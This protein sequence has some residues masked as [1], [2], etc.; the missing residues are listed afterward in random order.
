MG[1]NLFQY[2][3]IKPILLLLTV[4]TFIQGICIILQ[5]KWLAEVISS[6]FSGQ[7][8][9]SQL[10]KTIFFLIAFSLRHFIG[11]LQQK[12]AFQFAEKT[13][14]DLRQQFVTKLFE[15]GPRFTKHHGTGNLVT[16][17][18]EGIN[19]FRTY[20]E[21]ILPRMISMGVVPA[22]VLVYIFWKDFISG[23]ILTVT[24]PIL[25]AFLILVGLT[26]KKQMDQQ[27]ASY[28]VLSNHF[29]DSLRG[30]ETLKFLGKSKAHSSSIERVSHKYRKAT[31]GTLKVA[32]L[33]S[34]SLDFFSMLSIASVAVGLGMR[35]IDGDLML[36]TALSVLIL[37][38]EYF[39]PVR[40]VGAD[41]HATL[42]GKEA[43]EAIQ[44]ILKEPS[45]E[46]M[47]DLKDLSEELQSPTKQNALTLSSISVFQEE[48]S[49]PTLDDISFSLNGR[50]KVGI[51]GES[52]AGKS[53]LIDVLS[54]FLSPS[55]GEIRLN[56]QIIPL[57]SQAWRN[58][59]T[60]I[61]QK[62]Y[63]FSASVTDNIR[64]YTPEATEEEINQAIKAAGLS[65]MVQSLP[66][67][68]NEQIGGGGRSLSGGQEQR[69]ALA[70]AF[71]S[72]RPLMFLDEPTSH[73]DIETEYELKKTML[74]LFKDKLVF[75]ATHRLH[76]MQEMD[77]IIV[78]HQGRIAE[79]GTHD[80]LVAQKGAYYRLLTT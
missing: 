6:L 20:L 79:I 35:L 16:L 3:G 60:Y 78:L 44:A 26:A 23:I 54:G 70:R 34:F 63:I 49:P 14:K 9:Q 5:A 4:L 73:L 21:L 80:E 65:E 22:L 24:L 55:S 52:G 31:M 18:L 12:I 45:I 33:S 59:T 13:S 46:K 47:V 15:L 39:L 38:P 28:R 37:A 27:W 19:H 75:L 76:W 68:M 17:V 66:N 1:R 56:G 40:M 67:R 30:L 32:F 77:M 72:K 43:G 10:P 74:S 51:I 61:P 50:K 42:N 71:L 58:Q 69:V 2:K 7:S 53:T 57:T 64:F 8:L 41:Y 62:P 29:L 48:G 25:I 11:M 36:V